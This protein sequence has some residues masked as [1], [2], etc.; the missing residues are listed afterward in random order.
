M[1]FPLFI[2]N[3]ENYILEINTL[4]HFMEAKINRNRNR[5]PK[6]NDLSTLSC[7]QSSQKID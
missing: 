3:K 5:L 7:Q 6:E 2:Q 1:N 4:K